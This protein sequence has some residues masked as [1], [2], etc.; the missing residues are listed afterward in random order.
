MMTLKD[1]GT[2]SFQEIAELRG[3]TTAE[4]AME[5]FC[6]LNIGKKP[7]FKGVEM[8]ITGSL[9]AFYIFSFPVK[10]DG[11]PLHASGNRGKEFADFIKKHKLGNVWES[12]VRLNEVFHPEHSNQ[13]W[14]WMPD[15]PVLIAWWNEKQKKKETL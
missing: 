8:C 11:S 6:R 12:P 2:C 9:Y 3:H 1:T 5:T 4:H 14:V 7:M 10:H 13:L 15:K